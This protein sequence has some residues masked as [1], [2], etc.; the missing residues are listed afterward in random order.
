MI[1]SKREVSRHPW[2]PL[3][4]IGSKGA[5]LL[6]LVVAML[7]ALPAAAIAATVL[8]VGGMHQTMLP[9]KVMGRALNGKFTG[10]DPISKTPWH[11]V[12]VN[13]PA[14]TFPLTLSQ[15]VAKGTA[16]LVAAIK[17]TYSSTPG[18][19]TVVGISAGSLVVDEAMRELAKDP[20]APPRTAINFVV[21]ADATQKLDPD[22]WSTLWN[23][24]ATLSGYT[25]KPPPQTPYNLTVV[26]YEYDGWA[27]FPDRWWNLLAVQNA[28]A[29]SQLLHAKTWSVDLSDVPGV[30]TK[31]SAGGETTTYFIHPET[32]PLVQLRPWLAPMEASL[33][34]QIDAG[35]S[36][37]D[38]TPASSSP[39]SPV[40]RS[41]L[42]AS[43]AIAPTLQSSTGT[44][45]PTLQSSAPAIDPPAGAAASSVEEPAQSQ[46][47]P[48]NAAAPDAI[49]GPVSSTS[50]PVS[51]TQESGNAP[52][53]VAEATPQADPQLA[54]AARAVRRGATDLTGRKN[55]AV[56]TSG[57]IRGIGKASGII[58]GGPS[59]LG[60]T[61]VDRRRGTGGAGG[62]GGAGGI[63]GNGAHDNRPGTG[64]PGSGP[65]G[66]SGG[67]GST[68]GAGG[69]GGTGS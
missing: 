21:L 8:M 7:I 28:I 57:G 23:P 22:N 50:A 3:C 11:R 59:S 47:S 61:G 24:F 38:P 30:V 54:N 14:Q 13:W 58:G 48:E 32:L 31:N 52:V 18:P 34:Q 43:P 64:A 26:T 12:N 41:P 65:L 16:N 9:D 2:V 55:A 68:G 51:G 40:I 1:A 35:Y 15:S 44:I 19:I 25:Y 36:R 53:G 46:Q 49:A 10:T 4:V 63:S 69:S 67:A 66:T 5:V 20:T 37:N 42:T 62:A 39:V 29:G 33:K 60:V 6:A 45:A 27:D 17:S 56:R